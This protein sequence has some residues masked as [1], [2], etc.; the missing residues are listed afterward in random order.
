M[1]TTTSMTIIWLRYD[2]ENG[3]VGPR[4][5][6]YECV[7]RRVRA[8]ELVNVSSACYTEATRIV[9]LQDLKCTSERE[10]QHL[11]ASSKTK[12]CERTFLSNDIWWSTELPCMKVPRLG[13]LVLLRTS[14]LR[15]SIGGMILIRGNRSTQTKTCPRVTLST[16][17]PTRTGLGSNPCLRDEKRATDPWHGHFK[18]D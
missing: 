18:T 11:E 1:P 7:A 9:Q 10:I 8:I 16:T 14:V 13:L 2:S 6:Y 12:Q 5:V 17:N 4:S 3:S 15:R